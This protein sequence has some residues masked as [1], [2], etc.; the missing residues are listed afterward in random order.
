MVGHQRTLKDIWKERN[1]SPELVAGLAHISLPTLYS[2][3]KKE[4]RANRNNII[5]VCSVL[6]ITEEEYQE[7]APGE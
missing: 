1:M 2:M 7:L 4:R 5:A 3:N 6:D